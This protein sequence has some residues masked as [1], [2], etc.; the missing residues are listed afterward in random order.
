M[1]EIIKIVVLM[2]VLAAAYIDVK[3]REVPNVLSFIIALLG[4]ARAIAQHNVINALL[5][6][7]IVLILLLLSLK[8]VHNGLGF[9]D[10]KLLSALGIYA[11]FPNIL[12]IFLF[13][14]VFFALSAIAAVLFNRARR[15]SFKGAALPVVPFVAAALILMEIGV[16][17][18]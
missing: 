11:A 5:T 18:V 6:A 14:F 9:G 3:Q 17:I 8:I 1:I 12:N 4:L 13:T 7:L 16:T 10:I 2:C 15:G